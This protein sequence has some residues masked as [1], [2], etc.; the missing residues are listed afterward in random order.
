M[1]FAETPF[2]EVPASSATAPIP[3]GAG[4]P[5]MKPPTCAAGNNHT[6]PESADG[7]QLPATSRQ[8]MNDVDGSGATTAMNIKLKPR[9]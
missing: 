4:M 6:L 3:S 2:T 7:C 1:A 8:G 9:H 5:V